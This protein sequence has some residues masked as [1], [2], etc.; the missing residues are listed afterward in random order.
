MEKLAR[1]QGVKIEVLQEPS[2]LD[3][4]GGVGALLRFWEVRA[5]ERSGG[6]D[7]ATRPSPF[8]PTSSFDALRQRP[9][10]SAKS[11]APA[12]SVITHSHLP[13]QFLQGL[14][15]F[16][17]HLDRSSL[18]Q[19]SDRCRGLDLCKPPRG[20]SAYHGVVVVQKAF[21]D[22]HHYPSPE[23]S[24]SAIAT[25][26]KSPRHLVLFIAVWRYRC[27]KSSGVMPA[28]ATKSVSDASTFASNSGTDEKGDFRFQGQTSWQIS[29]PKIQLPV[30]R[31]AL[32]GRRLCALWLSRRCS[33]CCRVRTVRAPPSDR[34]RC[35]W[36]TSRSSRVPARHS[37]NPDRSGFLPRKNHEPR[38]RLKMFVF[39]PCQPIPAFTAQ[40][41]S[42]TGPV[43]T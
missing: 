30:P 32:R 37:P 16:L 35:T 2:F 1:H 31:D 14:E 6:L 15:G 25:L 41:F 23:C 42:S 17:V 10:R 40:A 12:R 33:V 29:H 21:Q 18:L 27:A 36:C 19:Q 43:S 3:H 20:M 34:H 7:G 9:G 26:R 5:F 28:S 24:R 11:G 8:P 39:F 4:L 22:G 38:R 13:E